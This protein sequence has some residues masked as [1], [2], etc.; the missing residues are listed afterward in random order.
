MTCPAPCTCSGASATGCPSRPRSPAESAEL[1]CRVGER[2][3]YHLLQSENTQ[4]YAEA[5]H[6]AE[7]TVRET[8]DEP[9]TWYRARAMATYAI[10]LTAAHRYD[11]ARDWASRAREA[12]RAAGSASVEADALATTGQ[13]ALRTGSSGEAIG[14]FTAAIE[15]AGAAGAVGVR[16]RAAYQLAAERL[17]RGELAEAGSV[18]HRGVEWAEAEGL[19]LAPFGLDLQ[20]LHFQAH[21]AEGRWDAAQELADAFPVRVTRQAEAVLSA[22]ALFIDVARGNP[23][24]GERR[25]W[26]EPFW[27]DVFVAYI[28]RGILAEH[29]LW[30]G[31]CERCPGGGG[32]RDRRGRVARPQ[33][34]GD[35]GDGDRARGPGRPGG[36]AAGGRGCRRRGRG[37]GRRCRAARCRQGGRQLPGPAQ[38]GARARGPRLARPLRSRVRPPHRGR[39]PRM[40]G[41]GS[42]LSSGPATCTRRRAPSGG[43]PR[44]WWKTG[45]ATRPPPSG[46]R[47]AIPRPG[48][49]RRPSARPS[50]TWRAVLAW[51]TAPDRGAG[52]GT[53]DGQA[54]ASPLAALTD[55]ERE[56]LGLLAR[57]MSN[58]E[59]GTE[60]FITPKTASVHVSNILGKLGAASRTEAAAIAY[61]ESA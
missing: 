52:A 53:A 16:L 25:I 17:A 8:L 32:S 21:F 26:L 15:Q 36:A 45:A 43:S 49:A 35:P 58:R 18:A 44:R 55:R 60:L 9:P 48:C 4:W 10:A 34:V 33:P 50:T 28:A 12:A 1:R 56:V 37:S 14:M 51:T 13:L 3:A 46:A 29:A 61:R 24:V 11:D 19:A 7:A 39:T 41:R 30:Q 5:L 42:S 23:A 31:D 6:V 22:M 2:L 54:D 27:D 57:G 59:I 47:R 20:H 38:G 40:P